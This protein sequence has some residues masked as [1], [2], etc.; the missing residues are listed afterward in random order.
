[1]SKINI[2]I[3]DVE[4]PEIVRDKAAEAFIQIKTEGEES[5]SNAEKIQKEQKKTEKNKN[6]IKPVIAAAACVA[7]LITSGIGI[8]HMQNG[9]QASDRNDNEQVLNA[10]TDTD[11]SKILDILPDFSITAYAE[12]LDV[13]PTRE[14]NI[15]FADAGHGEGGYTGIQFSIH[16]DDIS[17]VHVSL[18][19]GELYSAT[20]ER[21]TEDALEDWLAQGAPDEDNDP[22]T[23]TIIET[24]PA[25]QEDDMEVPQSVL[26]HHCTKRG[27]EISESYNP[28]LYYGFYIPDDILST[29]GEEDMASAYQEMLRVFDGSVLK[30]TV[31]YTNGSSA[32]KEYDLTVTKLAQDENGTVTNEEWTGGEEG[33]FVYGILAKEKNNGRTCSG[34]VY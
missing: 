4:V 3:D 8:Q 2:F 19:K 14:G 23:W 32:E 28:E 13:A 11:T 31:F 33:A 12:E 16:G 17:E 25:V 18:D 20:I 9:E 5:M 21:T 24:S 26:L 22:D 6:I 29:M 7:V 27:K 1:M 30:V 15:I 34:E 10:D